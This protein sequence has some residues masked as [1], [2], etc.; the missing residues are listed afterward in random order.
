MRV[1]RRW[2]LTFRDDEHGTTMYLIASMLQG[3]SSITASAHIR[4]VNLRLEIATLQTTHL[5]TAYIGVRA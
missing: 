4:A 3:E 5:R 1:E 2:V